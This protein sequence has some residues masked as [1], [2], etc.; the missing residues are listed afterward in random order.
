MRRLDL[1]TIQV[2]GLFDPVQ[3]NPKEVI[4]FKGS[5]A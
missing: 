5:A 2:K 4:A 3:Y 1:N